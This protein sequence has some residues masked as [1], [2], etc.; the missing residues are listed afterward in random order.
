MNYHK[1]LSKQILKLL[2][3][4]L[5]HNPAMQQFLSVVNESYITLEREKELSDRAFKI[6]E[7]EYSEL[8]KTLQQEA[9]VKRLSIEKLKE[10]VGVISGASLQEDSDDLLMI[11]EML[12]LQINKRKNAEKVFTSLIS[13]MQS[14]VLLEDE[15]RHIVFAN[16]L[17]CDLFGVPVSPDDLQGV[18]CADSAEQHKHLFK[19]PDKF[20][21]NIEKILKEKKLVNGEILEL[22]DGRIIER[23]FIPIT[24]DGEYKGHL[25]SYTDVT[26]IV[27]S[28]AAI[29]QSEIKTRL[30]MNASLDAIITMD[31]YGLIT[32]WNHQAEKIFGWKA[33]EVIGRKLSKTIIPEAYRR[34]HE[35]GVLH[36]AKVNEGTLLNKE[37]EI[38][39]INRDDKEFPAELS[40]IP[41]KQGNTE[42]LCFFIKDISDRKKYEAE[43]ERLSLIIQQS[44]NAILIADATGR[45]EWVND[46]YTKITGYTLE[47]VRGGT[48]GL[49]KGPLTSEATIRF[50]RL[51]VSRAEPFVCEI[52][53][54][55]KSGEGYWVRVNAQPVFDKDNNVVQYFSYEEDI[56]LEKESQEKLKA[57]ATRMSSLITNLHAGILLSNEDK[58]IALINQH[59]CDLFKIEQDPSAFVGSDCFASFEHVSQFFKNEKSFL[60]HTTKILNERKEVIGE[61]LELKD[62]RCFERDFVPVWSDNVY[63]GHLWVYTDITE[64]IN[65]EKRL[66]EQ[67]VFYEEILDNIPSDIAVFDKGHRYLYINPMAIKDKEMRKWII[68]KTDEEYFEYRNKPLSFLAG[69]RKRMF[70]KMFDT[71]TKTKKI[72]SWE[73]EMQGAD[74]TVQTILRNFYPVLNDNDEVK[75]VI[76]YGID[77]TDIKKIQRE[78]EQSEKRYRDVIDNSM[79]IITTHDMDGKFLTVNPMVGKTYGYEDEEILGHHISDF[80]LED[81]KKLFTESYL[82]VIKDN[83]EASG[84]LRVVHKS[85]KLL[86][87][88]YN[89]FLKEE[90][91][92]APYVIGFSVDITDRIMAEKE[93]KI[94]KQATEEMAQTKQNFLANMSHE[95]RTPM[96]AILGM[97]NLLAKTP[98]NQNQQFN[99][100]VIQSSAEN[101]MVIINDILDLSKIEAGKLTLENIAFELNSVIDKAIQVMVHKAEEKGLILTANL[102]DDRVSKILIGDP[103]RLNQVLLNLISNAI[104]F[105][106]KGT[107]DI[108]CKLVHEQGQQQT[109]KITVKDTGIGMDK[110]FT[111]DLFKK[112]TQEDDSV[113]RRFGGTGLGMSI[114]KELIELMNGKI[115]VQSQKGVGTE[116]SFVIPFQKGTAAQLPV[117]EIKNID[118]TV[119]VNKKVLIV[120]DNEMNRLVAA[121]ILKNYGVFTDEAV[122]GAEAVEKIKGN[123]YDIVLMDVHMPIMNGIEATENIRKNI[124]KELP[125]IALTAFALKDD[126]L[127]CLEVGMND[128]LSKPFKEIQLVNIILKW[129]GK[130]EMKAETNSDENFNVSL[131]DLSRLKEIGHNDEV[132]IKKMLDIF[133]DQIPL[134]I[135]EMNE[136]YAT[137]NFEKIKATAHRIKP[138]IDNMGIYSLQNEIR[139]I[140]ILALDN[141]PSEELLVLI[142]TVGTVLTHVVTD[143]KMPGSREKFTTKS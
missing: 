34:A 80:M 90:E 71:I 79:A 142:Q 86:Y 121:T 45:V 85:G 69:V 43:L 40:V 134:A 5:Q 101:L 139:R 118:T 8:N 129:L 94:A 114:C 133:C 12:N 109:I 1:L 88:L 103:Y 38:A 143:I 95:I 47:E 17:F 68:G 82:K 26:E 78:I 72:A 57:A 64:K 123:Q 65:V 4:D 141:M 89:N 102:F 31:S 18:D 36:F 3:E 25:W 97:T 22:D 32:F 104:K 81:D 56:T 128:Y 30:I 106:E 98:L 29:E 53:N 33:E 110:S 37:V 83:K 84:I 125:V 111:N 127:R 51:K 48:P 112:F 140:E 58:T 100:E 10:A 126:N 52:Y 7:E 113:S 63:D 35:E 136:G 135:T 93:L 61:K 2:P 132:F 27:N 15:T 50:M 60:E 115:N 6:S 73:E 59:F 138:S 107:V 96:N 46:A 92:R 49:A 99:L 14:G 70:D 54:Y 87:T 77:I 44:R 13:N 28:E 16:Q 42:F 116:F 20:V 91:G 120:D 131:Y 11:A 124:S 9:E 23:D 19:S 76:G 39:A 119:L 74:N 137:N 21:E 66:D 130:H 108:S 117:K 55:K 122:N 24:I 67:R 41:V 105:T 75:M 62:G